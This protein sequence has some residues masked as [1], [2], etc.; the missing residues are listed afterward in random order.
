MVKNKDFRVTESFLICRITSLN[1]M[2]DQSEIDGYMRL[3]TIVKFHSRIDGLMRQ[4]GSGASGD[5]SCAS[6]IAGCGKSEVDFWRA[7]LDK[8]I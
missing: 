5:D 4:S 8:R 1:L 6:I 7:Y 2:T 3:M